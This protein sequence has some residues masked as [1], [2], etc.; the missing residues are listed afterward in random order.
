MLASTVSSVHCHTK[1]L[2]SPLPPSLPPNSLNFMRYVTQR[3]TMKSTAQVYVVTIQYLEPCP[4]LQLFLPINTPK[5]L[6][7][8]GF[9]KS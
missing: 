7:L 6:V 2:N 5:Q 4:N 3:K 8:L 9:I 1:T